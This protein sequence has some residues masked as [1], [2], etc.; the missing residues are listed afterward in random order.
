MSGDEEKA[1]LLT[2]LEQSF[3]TGTFVRLTLGKFRGAGEA[4]KLVVTLVDLKGAIHLKFVT[5]LDR[6]DITQNL[7]IAEGVATIGG[8]LGKDFL[9]ATLFTTTRD[10]TLTYSKKKVPHLTQAMPTFPVAPAADHNRTKTYIVDPARGYLKVLGVT[11]DDGRV[12]P[13]MYAKFK[14]ICHFIEIADGLIHESEIKAHD[15]ISVTDIGSG[16]GYLTF[17]LYDHLTAT[18]GRR[19][20]VT[21]IEVRQDLVAT[22]NAAATRAGFTQLVFEAAEA[23]TAKARTLDIVVA[24]H[25]CDTATDDAIYTGIMSGARLIIAAPCC[26]HELAPQL[27]K[28]DAGFAGL[29]KFGLFKQRQADLVTDAARCLL[30]EA[31]GFRV[32]VIEFV[33]T[34]HTAKN[35]LIAGVR[36]AKTD[37]AEAE[38]Q[39][40]A[41]KAWAGFETQHL[42]QLLKS[43][44]KC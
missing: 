29:M 35:I 11:L 3:K 25:A 26:Q 2:E 27:T 19:A 42:E 40:A 23:R 34:E 5:S 20:N 13:S 16:K 24:L 15:A 43:R 30:L 14:Q 28:F 21:G 18:L 4:Q 17:A 22:C 32:K 12:K 33:A 8:R 6:K 39:Y 36:S 37:R 44:A 1:K 7:A 9:S 31:S 41:L 38:R 10:H